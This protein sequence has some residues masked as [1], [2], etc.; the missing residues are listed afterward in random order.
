MEAVVELEEVVE[1]EALG[2]ERGVEF[3]LLS[4]SEWESKRQNFLVHYT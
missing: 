3:R 2:T 4:D 1:L